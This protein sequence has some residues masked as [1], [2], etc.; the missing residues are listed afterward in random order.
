MA[1]PPRASAT[2]TKSVGIWIRVSTEDQAKGESPEHHEQRAR[3]YAASREWEIRTVYHLE[4]V[5]GKSV[6]GHPETQRMLGDVRTGRIT[7]LIF[8]KLA[9]LARNTKELLEFADIF[10]AIDA[11]LISLQEAIDTS[12]P[13]GR[14]FYTMI[15]GMAQ[16]EREE[17]ASR[18][19]ASI[20]VR[21]KLGKPLGGS[22]PFGYRWVNR[23]LVPDA[24]E[25]PTRTL[26][27]QL[28]LEHRRLKTVARLLNDRG[29]RTR[30]AKLFSDVKV[31]RIIRDPTAKGSRRANFSRRVN[32]KYSLK[33]EADWVWAEV[34]PIVSAELWEQC[35]A[36]LDER[37]RTKKP[38]TKKVVHLF[39]GVA[40]CVC[41]AKMYVPSTS[42]K[43]TC[44]KCRNKVPV[45]DLESVFRE[46][47]QGFVFSPERIAQH[48]EDADRGI[49]EKSALAASL[50]KQRQSLAADMEKVYRL[51]I[52]DRISPEGFDLRYRP[53]EAQLRQLDD[54]LPAL[55][56]ELD[57]LKI[58]YLS[59]QEVIAEARNL[60][61]RWPDLTSDEKRTVVENIVQTVTVGKDEISIDLCYLPSH[62]EGATL[63]PRHETS[64]W[65]R[66]PPSPRPVPRSD[67]CASESSRGGE[68]SSWGTR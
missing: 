40:R 5:S 43:Y 46:Q 13:A 25:A 14:L 32:G 44:F 53:M 55:Q 45:A 1:L 20:P 27:Y 59:S 30:A 58:Q 9:R 12:T 64:S 28:F 7:G 4:A 61:A 19:A 57:F 33:P 31:E 24:R 16:W 2:A 54:Q 47:L 3:M 37:R 49:T 50:A 65:P 11:D 41:G 35:N 22:T 56:G 23:Q 51:Y 52:N 39:A 63:G 66:R 48:L 15:A 60:Y 29:H 18:V 21:A 10:K 67:D 6:M 26:I 62:F 17:I 8:S 36:I 68:P 38:P 34:E 42:P